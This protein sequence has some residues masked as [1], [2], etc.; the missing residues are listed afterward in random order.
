MSINLA[1]S[2]DYARMRMDELLR[3]AEN[4]Y[5]VDLAVGPRRSIRSRLAGWLV[6]IAERVEDRPRAPVARA[7]A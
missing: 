5:L 7:E 6:A 4:D 3:E 2:D 1:F